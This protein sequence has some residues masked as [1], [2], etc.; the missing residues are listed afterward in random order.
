MGNAH[1]LAAYTYTSGWQPG[2]V[3]LI[4]VSGR[5]SRDSREPLF[6]SAIVQQQFLSP[7]MSTLTDQS[8]TIAGDDGPRHGGVVA[9]DR[10]N[11]PRLRDNVETFKGHITWNHELEFFFENQGFNELMIKKKKNNL[12]I[13]DQ[14]GRRNKIIRI[15]KRYLNSEKV[16][17]K[18]VVILS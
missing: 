16:H 11:P 10:R 5:P 17:K 13:I 15:L 2:G 7:Q 9:S 18:M 1:G 12:V 6:Y 4:F 8:Q 3:A 14:S